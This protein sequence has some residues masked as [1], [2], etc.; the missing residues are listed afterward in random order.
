MGD[1]PLFFEEF[2][3]VTTCFCCDYCWF[4]YVFFNNARHFDVLTCDFFDVCNR[5]ALEHLKKKA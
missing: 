3:V 2:V 1:F 4:E 5:V